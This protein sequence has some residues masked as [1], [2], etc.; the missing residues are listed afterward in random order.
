MQLRDRIA[1][2]PPGSRIAIDG[3]DASG[4][5]TLAAELARHDRALVAMYSDDY[6][7]PAEYEA[8]A[9]PRE[10]ADLVHFA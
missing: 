3:V 6:L 2:L 5:T 10:R 7:L 1:A 8:E 9:A 4:K